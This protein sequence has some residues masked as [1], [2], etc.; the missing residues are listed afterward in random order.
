MSLTNLITWCAGII[1]GLVGAHHIDDIHRTILRAQARLIYE[2]RTAN[3]GAPKFLEVESSL[4]KVDPKKIQ[5]R[6]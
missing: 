5:Q 3:W 4:K 1:I 6:Q 2:S